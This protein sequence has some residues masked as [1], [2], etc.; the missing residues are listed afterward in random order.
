MKRILSIAALLALA[1][2][3]GAGTAQAQGPDDDRLCI[4]RNNETIESGQQARN[5]IVI[6]CNAIVRSGGSVR[7]DVTVFGGNL[8]IEKGARIGQD[9]AVLGGNVTIGGE[10]GKDIAIVGGNVSLLEGAVVNG[11][12]R[13]AGGSLRRADGAIV[14]GSVSE[15]AGPD[16]RFPTFFNPPSFTRP[17]RWDADFGSGL[18]GVVAMAALGVLVAALAPVGLQRVAGAAQNALPMSAGVGCISM[19]AL[20]VAMIAFA[21]TIIGIPIALLLVLATAVA[22]YFGWIGIG[23]LVGVRLLE[24]LRA[25]AIVPV[26]STLFGVVIL[27]VVGNVP[28]LGGLITLL[29]GTLGLGAALLTRFG[30]K[31]YPPVGGATSV[32]PAPAPYAGDAPPATPG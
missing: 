7:D 32:A 26:L 20:P 10:V 6:G 5:L 18:L 3:L 28:C 31:T 1:L 24:A 30:T 14:R 13:I 16:I 25:G 12:V 17:L 29:V 11:N 8:S 2:T 27:A 21:I 15:G 23:Y 9:I 22:W 19:I 4:G